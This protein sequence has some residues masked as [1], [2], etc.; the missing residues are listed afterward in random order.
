MLRHA[1]ASPPPGSTVV[2]PDATANC[3]CARALPSLGFPSAGPANN[4]LIWHA[5]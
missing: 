4:T 3:G 2:P 5:Y 1:G